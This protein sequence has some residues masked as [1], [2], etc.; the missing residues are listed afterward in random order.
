MEIWGGNRAT[1]KQLEMP[2]LCVWVYSRPHRASLGGG[3]V[4]YLS[5]CASGRVRVS[6]WHSFHRSDVAPLDPAE[7]PHNRSGK[8]NPRAHHGLD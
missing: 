6:C 8:R 4:Y 3:D 2:G 7:T 1:D 5:S